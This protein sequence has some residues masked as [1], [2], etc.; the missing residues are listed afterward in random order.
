MRM[1]II[2]RLDGGSIKPLTIM[3]I[4]ESKINH[5]LRLLFSI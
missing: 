4:W 2:T 3:R 5:K 1:L